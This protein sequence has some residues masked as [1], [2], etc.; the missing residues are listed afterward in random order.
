[1]SNFQLPGGLTPDQVIQG[2]GEL[3]SAG[4]EVL[5]QGQLEQLV[6]IAERLAVDGA[7]LLDGATTAQKLASEVDAEQAAADAAEA[8]KLKGQ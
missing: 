2:L 7:E 4:L 8:A 3:A 5:G 1:M 6:L